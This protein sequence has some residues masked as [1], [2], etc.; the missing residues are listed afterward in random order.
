MPKVSNAY[1]ELKNTQILDAALSLFMNKPLYEITMLDV[2]NKLGVSKGGVYRYF[3]DIDHIIIT[4]VNR[5]T[6]K[7]DYR[8]DIDRIVSTADS[9]TM[10]ITELIRFLGQ[11]IEGGPIVL[12]KVQF[13]LTVLI[14]NHPE[15]AQRYFD[16]LTQQHSANHLMSALAF[17]I[18]EGIRVGIF[19]PQVSVGEL[20]AFIMATVDGVVKN[21]VLERAYGAHGEPLNVK[22][23]FEILLCSIMNMLNNT[24]CKMGR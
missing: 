14:A 5:E 24:N 3:K 10:A 11:Y 15:K 6:E 23:V 16:A 17:N 21:V 22:G 13:E 1:I 2:V 8:A 18:S 20:M 12:A 19:I 9:Y 7:M 4:L